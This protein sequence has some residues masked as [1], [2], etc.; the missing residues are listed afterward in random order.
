MKK[1]QIIAIILVFLWMGIIFY[2]SHQH[3]EKSGNTSKTFATTIVNI[4]DF[5][6]NLEQ[7]RKDEIINKIEPIIRKI[8]HY[9]IYTIGGILLANNFYQFM[10]DEKKIIMASS[11]VGIF[12]SITD[13][14][15]QIFISNRAG[16]CIDVLIDSLGIFTG[17]T[18]FLLFIKI[19]QLIIGKYK[20][21]KGGRIN[22]I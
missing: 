1:K 4:L 15:H 16:R 17:I 20:T 12:Y 10:K 19:L 2:F 13:E 21:K 8:A 6:N 18:V 11:I 3:G 5:N 22:W 9:T 7:V 14:I